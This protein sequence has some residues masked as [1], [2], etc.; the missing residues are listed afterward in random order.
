M[1]PILAY[2]IKILKVV[3]KV[4]PPLYQSVMWGK[5]I[6]NELKAKEPVKTLDKGVK[7]TRKSMERF[8]R[9]LTPKNN[10]T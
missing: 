5:K 9:K 10:S 6:Y 1:G 8:R 4:G 7:Y 2:I 3:A